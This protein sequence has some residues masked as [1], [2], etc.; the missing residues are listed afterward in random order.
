MRSSNTG[1]GGVLAGVLI[2]IVILMALALVVV[3][4]AGYYL[5]RNVTVKETRNAKIIETPFGS[6]RVRENARFDPAQFGVPV[7]PGATREEDNRKL[8]SFEFDVGDTHKEFS[9]L[10]AEYTTTDSVEDVTRFYRDKLP[11][12]LVSHNRRGHV[13]FELKGEGYR[14]IV[15]VHEKSGLTHIG[16]ASVGEPESN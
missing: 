6:M 14:R 3:V 7:Y 4:G 9:V 13:Q 2:G 12:W 16:L 5:A 10:A 1:R 8:A 11:L 15:A